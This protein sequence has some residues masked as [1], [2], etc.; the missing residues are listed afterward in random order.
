MAE[1][2]KALNELKGFVTS[3]EEQINQPDTPPRALRD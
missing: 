3:W 1:L 2:E